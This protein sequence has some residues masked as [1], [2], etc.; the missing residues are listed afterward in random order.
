MHIENVVIGKPIDSPENIFSLD[1][2]DW[3]NN[4]KSKTI[5]IKER[6]LP[7]ILVDLKFAPSNGEIRRNRKDL[8]V[9]LDEPDFIEIKYGKKRLFILV[10][11]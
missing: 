2:K 9:N 4:E 3:E 6:F 10:G 5:F 11:N 7:K 8:V 1:Q